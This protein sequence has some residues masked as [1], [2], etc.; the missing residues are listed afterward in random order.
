MKDVSVLRKGGRSPFGAQTLSSDPIGR[1]KGAR[2]ERVERRLL[3]SFAITWAWRLKA[4]PE[5]KMRRRRASRL[6]RQSAT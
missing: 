1:N 5:P 2:A 4:G 3:H 6:V